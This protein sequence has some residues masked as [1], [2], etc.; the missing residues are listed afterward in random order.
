VPV[1]PV[2]RSRAMI[3][4]SNP[5]ATIEELTS[6]V[7]GDP[8]LTA[9]VIRAANSA[10][11]AP[12]ERV[13]TP[14]Q[15]VVRIGLN[16]VRRLLSAAVVEEQF[17]RLED[18]PLDPDEAWRYA[19]ATAVVA[20]TL[21]SWPED[22]P[23]AFT[24]G[25]VHDLGRLALV[26]ASPSRFT[27]VIDAVRF[28]VDHLKAE[29]DQF[30]SAHT[31]AGMATAHAWGL[32]QSLAVVMGLHHEEEVDGLTGA[33][34]VARQAALHAGYTDGLTPETS[35]P[36]AEAVLVALERVGGS[37]GLAAAIRRHRNTLTVG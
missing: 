7:V 33:V 35:T 31:D 9:Q 15:G 4:L 36:P 32:P 21:V 17:R 22:R 20:E 5:D 6:I 23:V 10:S 30:G 27:A 34:A 24:A 18:G 14:H 12:V 29:R 3:V 26:I 8:S 16:G 19:I 13:S 11:S 25:L 1:L 28:G 37:G 2:P